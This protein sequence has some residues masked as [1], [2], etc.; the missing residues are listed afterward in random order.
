MEQTTEEQYRRWMTL[1]QTFFSNLILLGFD[2]ALEQKKNGIPFTPDMF[3]NS[4]M[5][6]MSVVIYFLL[7]KLSPKNATV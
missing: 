2:V 1:E 7:V 4:N 6:G 3:R 5:K